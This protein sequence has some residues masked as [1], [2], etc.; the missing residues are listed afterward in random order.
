MRRKGNDNLTGIMINLKEDYFTMLDESERSLIK[1]LSCRSLWIF[2]IIM[3]V[4]LNKL[5]LI[6]QNWLNMYLICTIF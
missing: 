3:Q 6:D 1:D 2:M 5:F 4:K